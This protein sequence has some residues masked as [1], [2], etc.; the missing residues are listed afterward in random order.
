M[1]K[2]KSVLDVNRF[3]KSLALILIICGSLGLLSSFMLT[4]DKIHVL[5]D[6]SFQPACNINPVL[7]CGSVMNTKQAELFGVPNTVFG[8]IGYS[9][10]IVVGAAILAKAKFD[11]WFWIALQIGATGA[12]VFMHYLFYQG[13]YQIKAICPFCFLMWIS[14]TPLFWYVTVHNVQAGHIALKGRL[15]GVKR[16]IINHHLDLFILW[17]VLLFTILITKFWYYWKTLI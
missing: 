1:K 13:V 6:P 7:S 3:L 9:M 4:Y 8:L 16:F 5:M 2:T 12:F 11:R 15:A 10:L 17:Y 14:T